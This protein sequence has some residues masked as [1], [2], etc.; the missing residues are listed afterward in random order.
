MALRLKI[1]DVES[2]EKKNKKPKTSKEC[3]KA[4]KSRRQFDVEKSTVPA[5]ILLLQTFYIK[6]PLKRVGVMFSP[7]SDPNIAVADDDTSLISWKVS[8]ICLRQF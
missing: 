5:L 3:K 7:A 8:Y 4:L 2:I 1:N 6:K